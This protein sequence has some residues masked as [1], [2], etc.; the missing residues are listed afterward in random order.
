LTP[1]RSFAPWT[2]RIATNVALD[3]LKTARPETDLPDDL[4]SPPLPEPGSSEELRRK[5]ARAF[6]RLP[7]K[8]QVKTGRLFVHH[9]RGNASTMTRGNDTLV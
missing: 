6:R 8:L 4:P 2:R 1:K 7:P 5:T 3:H 9:P